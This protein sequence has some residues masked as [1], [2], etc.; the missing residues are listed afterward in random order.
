V[1]DVD[2]TLIKTQNDNLT[3]KEKKHTA[4]KKLKAPGEGGKVRKIKKS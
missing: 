2:R 3:E 1:P 4:S